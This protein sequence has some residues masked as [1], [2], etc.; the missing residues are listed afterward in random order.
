MRILAILSIVFAFSAHAQD[1]AADRIMQLM[2]SLS[3]Q[4]AQA[5]NEG[6]YAQ[7]KESRRQLISMMEQV[8]F[9][10][11]EIARQLSNLASVLNIL[12]EP[13]EAQIALEKALE[14]LD[15]NPTNDRVQIAVLHGNL[16][17][18]LSKQGEYE[19]ARE[20][21]ESELE[22]L[23]ELTMENTHFAA[24]ARVGIGKIEVQ[25]GNFDEALTHYEFAIP[26]FRS[27]SED[28]HPVTSRVL[29]EY[30][31]IQSNINGQ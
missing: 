27:I 20:Q 4:A 8:N 19:L 5:Q 30:E 28:T 16:G 25:L 3:Q 24:S 29:R 23:Q 22:T 17:E 10:P 14:L 21:Y 11:A 7:A 2:G 6:N 18:A 9:R 12:D 1:D 15:A 13:E 31:D 26:I